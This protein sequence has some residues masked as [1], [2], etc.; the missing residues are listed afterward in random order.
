MKI[1]TTAIAIAFG[2]AVLVLL[3]KFTLEPRLS[4]SFSECLYLAALGAFTAVAVRI[5]SSHY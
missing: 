1:S 5:V 4:W 3:A 2:P